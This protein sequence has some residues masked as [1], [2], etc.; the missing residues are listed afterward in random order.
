M[1]SDPLSPLA[2]VAIFAGI[3]LLICALVTIAVYLP[4]WRRRRQVR[5]EV[6]ARRTADPGPAGEPDDPRA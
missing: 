6:A 2:A 4:E 3:P 1:F 5:G